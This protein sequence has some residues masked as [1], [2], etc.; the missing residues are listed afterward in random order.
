LR[1][2]IDEIVVGDREAG[3]AL[4]R[5]IDLA[6]R[7][8]LCRLGTPHEV[9]TQPLPYFL[10]SSQASCVTGRRRRGETVVGG[11][12]RVD[13][14]SVSMNLWKRAPVERVGRAG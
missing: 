10:I 5:E 12:T 3:S 6:E 4:P 13:Q 7:V 9:A 11:V 14:S 2:L 1:I 8:P